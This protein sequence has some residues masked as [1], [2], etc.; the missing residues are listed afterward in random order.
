MLIAAII[1]AVQSCYYDVFINESEASPSEEATERH[2]I[3][4]TK[5]TRSIM[6]AISFFIAAFAIWKLWQP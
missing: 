6:I 5:V 2:G 1:M 4:A 3:K